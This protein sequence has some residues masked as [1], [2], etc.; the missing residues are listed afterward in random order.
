MIRLIEI[1]IIFAV[2]AWTFFEIGYCIGSDNVYKNTK[3][4]VGDKVRWF[5]NR[6][7]YIVGTITEVC[8][9]G[10][11]WVEHSNGQEINYKES[12]LMLD[13]Q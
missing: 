2:I 7:Q 3:F 13:E 1:S 8:E 5:C 4:K 6:K 9:D 11:Y 10:T 12:E